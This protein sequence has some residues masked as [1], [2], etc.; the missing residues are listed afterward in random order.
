MEARLKV[1]GVANAEGAVGIKSRSV[2]AAKGGRTG[3]VATLPEEAKEKIY[4]DY[5]PTAEDK[6]DDSWK[7]LK[8]LKRVLALSQQFEV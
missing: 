1:A 4:K 8:K 7:A 3:E 6:R 5:V 2:R